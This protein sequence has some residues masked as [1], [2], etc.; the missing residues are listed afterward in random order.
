MGARRGVK[1]Q[2]CTLRTN[3]WTMEK[4]GEMGFWSIIIREIVY[5]L[6]PLSIIIVKQ[7]KKVDFTAANVA[8]TIEITVFPVLCEAVMATTQPQFRLGSSLQLSLPTCYQ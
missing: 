2:G 7:L 1:K 6:D 8:E 3:F 5:G 4:E